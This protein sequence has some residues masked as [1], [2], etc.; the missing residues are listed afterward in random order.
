MTSRSKAR[1]SGSIALRHIVCLKQVAS[2]S[3]VDP[4]LIDIARVL[5]SPCRVYLGTRLFLCLLVCARFF[6][7]RTL[8]KKAAS[9]CP[10][11]FS[12]NNAV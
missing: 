12:A 6:D 9:A 8:K 2:V 1:R 7:I 10:D 3:N 4:I 11:S 5:A